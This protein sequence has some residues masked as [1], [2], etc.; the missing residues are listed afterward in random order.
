MISSL[1]GRLDAKAP[2]EVTL[3]VGGMGF[4]IHV[5]IS[6]F[7][8]LGA[9]GT[10][11]TLLT[12]LHVREDALQLFGFATEQERGMFRALIAVT[13]IGPKM[14]LGI[15]SGISV[16]DLRGH[17][18]SGNASALTAIPGV[19]RKTAERLVLE[20]REKVGR[21]AESAPA[22][23]EAAA[24]DR[25][26]AVLALVSLGYSRPAAE[27]AIAAAA[28]ALSGGTTTTLE[29]LIKAALKHAA[30]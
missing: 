18:L 5:P 17:I 8:V 20:L 10:E 29:Q 1:S 28:R 25:Q 6:T 9:P 13:G 26:E 7:E 14:A 22:G 24:S 12:H 3:S 21:S 4:A 11:I 30:R 15:L 27:Q 16:T 19:G 2:T 23:T